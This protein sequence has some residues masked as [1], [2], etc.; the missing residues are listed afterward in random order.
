V[1]E[2]IELRW[3]LA[4]IRVLLWTARVG[5]PAEMRP[6]V[7][8]YLADLYFRLAASYEDSGRLRLAKRYRKVAN[9]HAVNGPP[10]DLPPAVAMAMAVPRPWI[11]TDARGTVVHPPD[12][13]GPLTA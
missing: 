7:H 5:R 12:D 3:K 11:F 8:L 2:R 9:K 6:E 13:E 10:P 4:W 1:L